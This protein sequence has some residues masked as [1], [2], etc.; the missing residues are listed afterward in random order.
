MEEGEATKAADCTHQEEGE[1]NISAIESVAER[2]ARQK[3]EL[4]AL[5]V[6]RDKRQPTCAAFRDLYLG[7]VFRLTISDGRII[8]GRLQCF[9]KDGNFILINGKEYY[10]GACI[11]GLKQDPDGVVSVDGEPERHLGQILVPGRH[12]MKYEVED[13]KK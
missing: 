3:A 6:A 10:S 2:D 7:A 8:T 11:V 9:D 4:E 1:E 5:D 13:K 12:I